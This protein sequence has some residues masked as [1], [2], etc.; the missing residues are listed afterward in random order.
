MY[1][2]DNQPKTLDRPSTAA[3]RNPTLMNTWWQ[4]RNP[5]LRD[6]GVISARNMAPKDVANPR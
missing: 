3:M 2:H 6:I 4:V 5:P 1:Y